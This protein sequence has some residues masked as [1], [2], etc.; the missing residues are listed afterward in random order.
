MLD[1]KVSGDVAPVV[2]RDAKDISL[3]ASGILIDTITEEFRGVKGV[4]KLWEIAKTL[5]D[6]EILQFMPWGSLAQHGSTP[7]FTTLADRAMAGS[8][9]F[10]TEKRYLG[11]GTNALRS[12]GVVCIL[13]GWK[14]PFVLCPRGGY[15]QLVREAFVYGIIDGEAIE[16]WKMGKLKGQEFEIYWRSEPCVGIILALEVV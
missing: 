12:D 1:F 9:L 8:L 13:F 14:V 10:C 5:R 15:Y 4:A 6:G 7:R 11:I 2:T 3:V 16:Y